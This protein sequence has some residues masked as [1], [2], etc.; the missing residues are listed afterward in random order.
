IYG[1]AFAT[2]KE[3]DDYLKQ[4]EAAKE[5]D[6]RKLGKELNLFTF[7]PWA[8]AAP[9]FLP[10][11][12]KIY[13]LLIDY[14]RDLYRRHGYDEVITPQIFENDLFLSWGHW[15]DFGKNMFLVGTLESVKKAN[16]QSKKAHP[17]AAEKI[18]KALHYGVKPMNCPSHCLLFA[19][20]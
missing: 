14:I 2:Q 1:T 9:F 12:A 3:L 4:I 18:P 20:T 5:R 17:A 6:H 10:R 15:R 19:T 13:N 8:P 16:A 11:G 7:H